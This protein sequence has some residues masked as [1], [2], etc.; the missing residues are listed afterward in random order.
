MGHVAKTR[1]GLTGNVA[2]ERVLPCDQ[3]AGFLDALIQR[4][5]E[6]LHRRHAKVQSQISILE[7]QVAEQHAKRE[8]KGTN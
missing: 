2:A 7:K 8:N 1:A 4:T 6:D 3:R 5:I